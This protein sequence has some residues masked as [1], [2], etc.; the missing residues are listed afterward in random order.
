MN[1]I[2]S[3]FLA[4]IIQGSIVEETIHAQDWR[5]PISTLL[6][7]HIPGATIYCHYSAHPNSITYDGEKIRETFDEGVR[8]CVESDLTIC[9]LPSASMGTAIEMYEA[10]RAGKLVVTISPLAANWVVRLYSHVI[11]PDLAA[12]E[13]LLASGQL[14]TLRN[15]L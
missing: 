4:G 6:A 5:T 14:D 9:Y 8:R 10:Y 2:Q 13:A 11:V 15:T 12:F 7:R 1:A 3:I